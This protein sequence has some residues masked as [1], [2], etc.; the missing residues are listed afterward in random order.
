MIDSKKIVIVVKTKEGDIQ[1]LGADYVSVQELTDANVE[2]LEY[3]D[4]D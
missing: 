2:V 1:Y 3:K 4:V